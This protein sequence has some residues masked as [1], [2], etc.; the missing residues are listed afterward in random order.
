MRQRV[1]AVR[2]LSLRLHRVT[3][4]VHRVRRRRR[5]QALDETVIRRLELEG[6]SVLVLSLSESLSVGEGLLLL[7]QLELLLEVLSGEWDGERRLAGF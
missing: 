2:L 6:E 5:M 3:E 4:S 1:P 7:L